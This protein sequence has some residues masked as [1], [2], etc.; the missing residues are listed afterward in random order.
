MDITDSLDINKSYAVN[1]HLEPKCIH[2]DDLRLTAGLGF[3]FQLWK[4]RQK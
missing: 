4:P 1:I 3:N 2:L